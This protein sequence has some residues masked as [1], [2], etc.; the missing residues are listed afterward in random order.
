MDRQTY[1]STPTAMPVAAEGGERGRERRKEAAPQ[2][3]SHVQG[4]PT[5]K[6]D[7]GGSTSTRGEGGEELLSHM[8]PGPI[9]PSD[10]QSLLQPA[11][12][13]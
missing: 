7:G 5:S 9:P 11:E 12:D 10:H 6:R 2:A 1:V 8:N 13:F 4:L 3:G